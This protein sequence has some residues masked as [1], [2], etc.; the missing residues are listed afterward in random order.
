MEWYLGKNYTMPAYC[1]SLL[2]DT[3][4]VPTCIIIVHVYISILLVDNDTMLDDRNNLMLLSL[5]MLNFDS[6]LQY[7][8]IFTQMK[9]WY[10]HQGLNSM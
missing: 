6:V 3:V 9:L 7:T 2:D 8:L 10:K 5:S 1:H 4:T